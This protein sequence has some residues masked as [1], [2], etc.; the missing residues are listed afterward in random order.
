MERKRGRKG[1][2]EQPNQTL[3]NSLSI[4]RQ[5]IHDS[6]IRNSRLWITG[7]IRENQ[8]SQKASNFAAF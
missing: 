2:I 4:H 8:I 5:Q 6:K 1:Y 7:H 3:R